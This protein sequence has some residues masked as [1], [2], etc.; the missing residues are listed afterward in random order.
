LIVDVGAVRRAQ[1]NNIRLDNAASCSILALV[2]DNPIL[3]GS[4]LLGAAG[5]IHR[6]VGHAAIFANQIGGLAV[7]R[8]EGKLLVIFEYVESPALLWL[9][10]LRRLVVFDDNAVVSVGVLG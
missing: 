4:V 6:Y 8:E 9:A 2:L 3:E 5:M 10:S 1:V 7:Q